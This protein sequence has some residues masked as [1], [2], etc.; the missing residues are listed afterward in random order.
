MKKGEHPLKKWR[1]P[2][3]KWR[4]PVKKGEHPMEAE[5]SQRATTRGERWPEAGSLGGVHCGQS[6]RE[7]A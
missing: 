5:V 6:S 3:K 1:H 4:H 2:V 7:A